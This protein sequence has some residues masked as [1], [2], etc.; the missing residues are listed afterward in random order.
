MIK[1]GEKFSLE[2]L[3]CKRPGNGF[4]PMKIKTLLNIK[5]NKTFKPDDIIN[6]K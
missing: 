4:N 5:A 6:Q 2:N 3:V 1:K